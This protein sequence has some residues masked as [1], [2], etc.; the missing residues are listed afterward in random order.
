M[1]KVLNDTEI[2]QVCGGESWTTTSSGNTTISMGQN[3]TVV[4]TVNSNGT[5]TTTVISSDGSIS[6]KTSPTVIA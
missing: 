1:L 5:T 3:G 4:T 6:E 2:D